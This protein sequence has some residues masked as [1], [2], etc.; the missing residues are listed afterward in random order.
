M[1]P[2]VLARYLKTSVLLAL[3]SA[4]QISKRHP[5]EGQSLR[6]RAE[7]SVLFSKRPLRAVTCYAIILNLLIWPSPKITFGAI[8]FPVSGVASTVVSTVADLSSMVRSLRSVPVIVIPYGPIVIPFPVLPIWPFNV[9]ASRPISM[10][11]RTARV[12]TIAVAPHRMVGYIGETV[13]FV[14]MGS[15][16]RG[17]LVHGAKFQWESSDTSKL[18]IDQAAR[19]IMVQPGMVIV[20]A[21]AGAAVQTAPVLIRPIRRPVQTDQQWRADQESFVSSVGD[22]EGGNGIL[23]SLTDRLMPTAHAQFNTWGDNPNAAGQIGTPPFTALEDTRLGPVIPGSNFELPIPIVSLGGRGLATSLMLYYNSSVWGSY[24]DAVGN[25]NVYAFDPIQSW[26]SAGFSL[27]FGRITYT[28]SG[29]GY[30]YMLIDPNGTRHDL[31]VGSD[32]GTNTLQTTDG[33][34]I[35]YAGNALG[36][37]MYF[38]DGTAVTIGKV[39]NRLLPTQITDTNGNYDQIAYHWE[40]NYPP[41]AINYVVDTLGRVIQFHYDTPNST[42]L[43]SITTPAGTVSLGYQTVT[44][45]PNFLL[46][47]PIENMPSSFSA[48][49]SVT[50]P[51]KP[52]YTF[53]YTGYGMIYNIVATSGGGTATVSY[54]CPQGGDQVLW[55]TFSRRTESGTPNDAVFIYGSDGSITRP[56]GTRLLLSGPDKELRGSTNTTLSKTVSTLSTDPGGS[57]V[58]QSVIAY[59]EIGQQT[60]VDFDYDGYGNVVNKREY[61]YQ[62]SSAWKVRRRTHYSYVNWEPYL[63]AYIRNRVTETDV[64]DAL[65]NTSD[66][67][68]V[69]VGKTVVGYDSY[70]AMGGMENYGGTAAP[71]GHLSGYD[72]SKT[73]RGNLTGVTTYSDLSGSGVTRSSK[74]DIFGGVTKAQ[75]SCCNA[76]SFTMT[77]A[78]YWSR[79][80]QTT[81]GDQSSIHLTST[82]AYDF[83]ILQVTSQTD[84]DSQTT[85]YSYDAAGR[86]SGFTAPTGATGSVVYNAFGEKTSSSVT[87][88]EGGVNK[89][90][91]TSATYDGWGQMTSSIDAN[92]AQTNYTYDNM[93]HRLTQ[94]NPFQQGGTPGPST[95]YQYD[96]L[97][98]QTLMTL[99]GGNTNQT[100]YIGGNIVTMTDQVNR[101]TKRESDSLGRLIT[102]TEQDVSSGA[103]TQDTTYT[104]DIADH[105]IGVNQGNQTR[106]YK[107]DAEGHLLFERI[108]EMTASI[109][110]GTGTYW[111]TKYTYTTFGAV[112]TKTDARGVII[113]YGYDNLNRLTSISYNTSGATG[114]DSTNNVAYTYDTSQTSVTNGLLLSITMSGPMAT[115]TETLSYDTSKRIGSRTWTRDSLSYTT[116]YQYNTGNQLT[117]MTYP[118]TGRTLNVAHDSAGRVSSIADQYR[119]YANNF[120]FNPA[121]QVT[122]LSLGNVATETYG[123]DTNRMQ[124]ISQTATQ[125]GGTTNGLMNLHYYYDAAAGQMG[126]GSTTGNA[127]QLMAINN[128]STINGT[129]E[130]AAYT[131]DDLGR[132]VTSNQTS[133]GSSAQRRFAYERWGNRTG[134]WDATSGGTQI[135]SIALQ[136]SSGVPT[137]QITS[138]TA[139]GSTKNYTYDANGNLINDGVHVYTYDAENRLR[140]VDWGTSNQASY[141]YDYANRRIKKYT[142]AAITYYAWQGNQVI[143]EY[144]STG[145]TV[146][147]YVYS[148]IRLIARMGSG[149]INW[150]LSDRLS[151][152]LVLDGNAG[153]I[154][155]MAH[156]PFG[157][158][159]GENG[160]QEK[161]HFTSYE[162]D[163]EAGSDYAV[164]R[165]YS[166]SVGRFMSADPYR[167]SAGLSN[168]QSLNR[169]TYVLN[170]SLDYVDPSGLNLADPNGGGPMSCSVAY[171]WA[172]YEG[173]PVYGPVGFEC[174]GNGSA[175]GADKPEK[176]PCSE[177]EFSFSSDTGY[178]TANEL[179]LLAE[180]ALGE[181]GFRGSNQQEIEAIIATVINR[182]SYNV[183]WYS[184]HNRPHF[185]TRQNPAPTQI[186]DILG[187]T[188]YDAYTAGL[189]YRKLSQAKAMTGG[190][191]T[192]DSYVCAQLIAAKSFAVWAGSHTPAE[193]FAAYPVTF[194]HALPWRARR[195]YTNVAS[196][197][198]TLFWNGPFGP[199]TF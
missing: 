171:G 146:Y 198:A 125:T 106:A 84:P 58:L 134:M 186:P 41:M 42:N 143:G 69:L 23:A 52:T 92:G 123:Y 30:R 159:F 38:N 32:T 190:V 131:Y 24:F 37:T 54:D 147:N 110:D 174:G 196:Y 28:S 176:T 180:V 98:R 192:E 117:Q 182:R 101:Q 102:V 111:T 51:V 193:V 22:G 5:I 121:G 165:Q 129:T 63:S 124:L 137:N 40:M 47:N 170:K 105:L 122:G 50:M 64:Y 197:G 175:S 12:A 103:L 160:T 26:P 184:D 60:R 35:T 163:S 157:E 132:L 19:A 140:T 34:H 14:A 177:Q 13:T 135:Q 194:F 179:S 199:P 91:S 61:G 136:Q 149:L 139:S 95:G 173:L 10:A 72:T 100:A 148:G 188:G 11:E 1:H 130:S 90:V 17:D 118:G 116:N 31:G 3:R 67:D 56:D 162:R 16:I 109:N 87:Y 43:T 150:Y 178:L 53:T 48:V 83:D 49:S 112:A 187:M 94:T 81:S 20:T 168:P 82:A 89:T 185:G 144:D 183:A 161:H 195:R 96:E 167:P 115:Y 2:S 68:D 108:P 120:T 169:Y 158:D 191:L 113:T 4:S 80:A 181:S 119:S 79:S 88:S 128:S 78:T 85:S 151:E 153:V 7:S 66:S 70:S 114:V 189:G 141:V 99:P 97:S 71:P 36:G 75:V 59:D 156:L 25:T 33:S 62:I 9:Q 74:I 57:T 145:A 45:N 155:R 44:M 104:Y 152:R 127:G 172:S 6:Q 73:T 77:E 126:T 107:Y 27:G 46:S 93:G 29:S 15:D 164:N 166:A 154:G 18:T 55:P 138:V 86:P 65:Q 142:N 8:T 76:K 21:R 39:N 133:N